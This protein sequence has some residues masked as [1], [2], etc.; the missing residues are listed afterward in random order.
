MKE[1]RANGVPDDGQVLSDM[2]YDDLKRT[3]VK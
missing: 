3:R 2:A 1:W